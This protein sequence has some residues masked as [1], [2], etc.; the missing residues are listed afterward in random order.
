MFNFEKA[1]EAALS[2]KKFT[3]SQDA[4]E[5]AVLLA[6]QSCALGTASESTSEAGYMA[7]TAAFNA[8]VLSGDLTPH[9]LLADGTF[10][11]RPS[12]KCTP[13]Y[14]LGGKVSFYRCAW[15]ACATKGAL[16]PDGMTLSSAYKA[17]DAEKKAAAKAQSAATMATP[18]IEN[19]AQ[20]QAQSIALAAFT[21]IEELA[22]ALQSECAKT[23]IAR[24]TVSA[25]TAEM[26]KITSEFTL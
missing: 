12:E 16:I 18:A 3:A 26:I 6:A 24:K 19:G 9:S 11:R 13:I 5:Q 2:G 25:I 23:S 14:K 8:A 21:Q 4:V 17:L 10:P 7:L 20:A 15:K 22:R 1:L